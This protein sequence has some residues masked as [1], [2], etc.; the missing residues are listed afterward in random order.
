VE[1]AHAVCGLEGRQQTDTVAHLSALAEGS[2]VSGPVVGPDEGPGRY[3]LL[4]PLRAF[5]RQR[6][7]DR[8]ELG[9][10]ADRH[11]AVFVARAEESAGPPL[12]GPGRRWLEVSLDDLRAARQRALVTRDIALLAR[13]VAALYRFDYW[14]PGNEL[15]AWADDALGMEGIDEEP[16]APRVKAAGAAAAWMRGDLER[17]RRLAE[18]GTTM[19]AGP[20]DPAR[21]LAFEA[22]A[23]VAFFEGRLAESE[24]AF[25]EAVRLA[26]L[27]GDPDGEVSGRTGVAL[28]LAYTGRVAD[29]IREAD[30]A[31]EV[32]GSAGQASQAFARFAQGEC[33]AETDPRR[34]MVLVGDAIDLAQRCDAWFVEGV[35]RVTAAS[36]RARHG[37][38]TSALPAFATLLRHWDRSGSWPQQ[39]TTLR[40]LVELLVRLEADEPAVAIAGASE[41]A[42]TAA[43]TYGVESDRLGKALETARRRLGDQRF[44]AA[45]SSGRQLPAREV[46]E[47]AL[48]TIDG[49][50]ASEATSAPSRQPTAPRS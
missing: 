36:L 34:A 49:L 32:A 50:L 20:D 29:G 33:L 37:V 16:T 17:A 3:R 48:S 35:A 22:L 10:L 28:T 44:E 42:T 39:W 19:G 43:P 11:A 12:T 8:G 31:W 38:T 18:E 30:V 1:E 46:V 26:R 25:R 45:R 47:L 4:R 5:A 9:A 15:L 2:L 6:L 41:V 40:N 27:A 14:R 21:L 7:A 24:G 23:D 13:L